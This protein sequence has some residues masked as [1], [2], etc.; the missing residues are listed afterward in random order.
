MVG[1]FIS[2]RR[3]DASGH[4]GRLRDHLR[5]RFGRQV[6]QDV[7]DIADGEIYEQ[8]LERALQTCGIGLVVIGPTWLTGVDVAHQRRLDAPDDWVRTEIRQLL[9]RGIRVIPVLVGGA[10][11]PTTADLPDD[12]KPLAKRQARELRD[13]SWDADVAAL[14]ARLQEALGGALAPAPSPVPPPNQRPL[15]V[16][17]G[18]G[19]LLVALAAGW[20]LWSSRDEPSRQPLAESAASQSGVQGAAASAPAQPAAQPALVAGRALGLPG[21][22]WRIEDFS[23]M[24][25]EP[26]APKTFE[27]VERDGALL[28]QSVGGTAQDRMLAKQIHDR[29]I[30]LL[31]QPVGGNAFDY[32]YVFKLA[33]DGSKLDQCQT[34]QVTDLAAL[35]PC[36][37]RY[38]RADATSAPDTKTATRGPTP[39]PCGKGSPNEA[40]PGCVAAAQAAGLAGAWI[41]S[42]GKTAYTLDIAGSVVQLRSTA[43]RDEKPWR[44]LLRSVHNSSVS[45][46]WA[47]MNNQPEAFDG[48]MWVEYDLVLV[49]GGKRLVKC[50][51]ITQLSARQEAEECRDVPTFLVQR[52]R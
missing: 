17:G 21:T 44:L 36:Q 34:V 35:G 3:H 16:A 48:Q 1:L 50:R 9:E 40:D 41:A 20:A 27:F 29:S 42:D 52:G 45:F 4:A 7:D 47:G 12:L 22:R 37:W 43:L 13:A 28:L 26:G 46:A 15:R 30:T 39:V 33:L 38:S 25:A 6:F 2:Y 11:M 19:A 10:R 24:E 31:P 14:M 51:A 23:G 8:V 32:M 18:A 5:T 49:G